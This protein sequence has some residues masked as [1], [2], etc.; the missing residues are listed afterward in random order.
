MA[1]GNG[2]LMRTAAV[3]LNHLDDPQAAAEAA[4]AV[5]DLTH[6]DPM[7]AEACVIWTLAI[8]HAVLEG[9][10]DGVR[11]SL[12]HL[13]EDRALEWA[14]LLDEAEASEP[15]YF[16]NNGW[17]VHALQAAWS[18]IV[19]TPMP[20]LDPGRGSFPAQHFALAVEAAVRAGND[21]DTVAAI[22]GSLLG[23]R[24]GTSAVPL[25][26]KRMLH[27]YPGYRARDLV[28]LAVHA[29]RASMGHWLD[30][31]EG[32]PGDPVV[33]YDGYSG[34]LIGGIDSLRDLPEGVDAVVSLCR[35]GADEV[36]ASGVAPQDHIEVWLV[37]SNHPQR[38]AHL[39]FVVDQAARAVARLREEGRT[40][41]LHCVQ[42]HS[43]TPT[44]A[45]RY[46]VIRDGMPA[47][48][49][50]DEVCAALP[51]AAP[52]EALAGAVR[53]LGSWRG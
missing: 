23:A 15:A 50:L 5:S 33:P 1:A 6:A 32:W 16:D 9:N 11:Q 2:A 47:Q 10:F 28:R 42:A 31:D 49:A 37:D 4:R 43:R 18:A 20:E 14:I 8:R 39:A 34:V 29:G 46:S 25:E 35:L 7:S 21:T 40:V 52:R 17:V 48:Q 44:V 30:D 3:A 53:Q 41:Y 36:P 45:A 24:W 51:A 12:D 19:R 38:N 22:A 27:G 13:P 26:W